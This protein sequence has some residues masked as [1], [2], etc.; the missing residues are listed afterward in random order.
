MQSC[1]KSLTL[2]VLTPAETLLEET[3]VAWV[4]VQLA[5]GGGLGIWPGHAPLL[6]ETVSAPLRY[7]SAADIPA[8]RI[9]HILNLEAGILQIEPGEVTVFTSGLNSS[10]DPILEEP[11]ASAR[12]VRRRS[13]SDACVP[14][15]SNFGCTE[16]VLIR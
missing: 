12:S 3:E 7:A 1:T 13:A 10:V 8:E 4:Q 2:R 5:D 16:S 6:A 14:H 9:E 11:A 15:S